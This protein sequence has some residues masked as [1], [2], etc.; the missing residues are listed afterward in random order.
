MNIKLK[1]VAFV[2]ISACLVTTA[3]TNNKK[4]AALDEVVQRIVLLSQFITST[5]VDQAESIAD[6]AALVNSDAY[7]AQMA[8]IDEL[9][10]VRE[11]TRKLM[12]RMIATDT[13]DL[14]SIADLEMRVGTA[15]A[16]GED[17]YY[18]QSSLGEALSKI[19]IIDE[20]PDLLNAPAAEMNPQLTDVEGSGDG[21]TTPIPN[22]YDEIS[23]PKVYRAI[24]DDIHRVF[25]GSTTTPDGGGF[26][27]TNKDATPI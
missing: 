16:I 25:R 10:E 21:L 6:N 24:F 26:G 17:I 3:Q 2:L 9:T 19:N 18:G 15:F 13:S 20:L 12:N 27:E 7:I 5:Q 14:A 4:Q 8:R 11:V 22:I 23:R 1:Y